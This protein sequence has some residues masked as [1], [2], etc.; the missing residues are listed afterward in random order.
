MENKPLNIIRDLKDVE[1]GTR[2]GWI[3]YSIGLFILSVILILS[4]KAIGLSFNLW[5]NLLFIVVVQFVHSSL[6]FSRRQK[7]FN[8]K[9]LVIAF[10]IATEKESKDY[11]KEIKKEF[12]RQVAKYKLESIIKIKELSS[13]VKFNNDNEAERYIK[14]K[15]IWVLLWGDTREG[16]LNNTPITQFNIKASFQFNQLDEEKR[17]SFLS[18]VNLATQRRVLSVWQKNSSYQLVI[19]SGN[20]VEI[21]LFTLGACL[22]TA[23]NIDYFLKSVL[24][25]EKLHDI[26]KRRKQDTNFPN[27]IFVK[28][29]VRS[30]LDQSFSDLSSYFW[31]EKKD[32]DKAIE[33]GEQAIKINENNFNAHQDMAVWR[34]LSNEP[35]LSKQ[36]TNRAWK[37]RPGNPLPRFNRAFYLIVDKKFEAGFREYKKIKYVGNT[38]IVNVVDFIENEF[39]KNKN[40]LG[41]LFIAGWLNKLHVDQIRGI[42]LLEDFLS[43]AKDKDEYNYLVAE[44]KKALKDN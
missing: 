31:Q 19:V 44:A 5:I 30:L 33:Y 9:N 12:R 41:F 38:N 14:K 22:A 20:I 27:L 43:Q 3:Y 42:K 36:H 7:I 35:E 11:Y 10:A 24:I 6:W 8:L 29:K 37:L 2:F 34:W 4:L 32:L 28:E 23:P 15:G 40:N 26:L 25:F 17:K 16:N 1:Y 21:S 18:D 13:D 39:E